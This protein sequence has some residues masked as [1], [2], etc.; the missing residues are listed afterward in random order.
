MLRNCLHAA[1]GQASED[2]VTQPHHSTL[3]RHEAAYMS[4]V[5]QQRNLQEFT[6][7]EM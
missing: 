1:A 5:D 6:I 7:A 4:Q 3:R 2:A